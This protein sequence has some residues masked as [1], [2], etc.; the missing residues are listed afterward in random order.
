M[1]FSFEYRK[2]GDFTYHVLSDPG[3][4]RAFVMKWAMREWEIDH[5]EAPDEHWTVAWMD[6]LPK[7]D[8]ALEVIRLDEV[9]PNPDLMSVEEFQISLKERADDRG[10]G[11][12]CDHRGPARPRTLRPAP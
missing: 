5:A 10:E 1:I 4:I 6:A 9:R 12:P 3:D 2:L 11:Q 7:M 8:F